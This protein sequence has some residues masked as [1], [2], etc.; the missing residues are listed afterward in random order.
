MKNWYCKPASE[1]EAIEIVRRALANGAVEK[2][3]VSVMAIDGY[4]YKWDVFSFWGVHDGKTITFGATQSA[5][6]RLN[7]Q[8]VRKHFPLPHEVKVMS[9]KEWQGPQDGLPPVGDWVM[10][11]GG[12]KMF[13]VGTSSIGGHVFE[14]EG[15]GL[16]V[17]DSVDG[18][19]QIPN[20]R[21]KWIDYVTGLVK[22]G[23]QTDESLAGEI[24]DALKSG[25]LKA[26]EVEQ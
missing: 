23:A 9:K 25:A 14:L 1:A 6:E 10:S 18:F 8:E 26:P 15:G 2:D 21:D 5:G 4:K 12:A 22:Q 3:V 17:V 11:P 13:Y 24:Y 16:T 19:S 20:E 7:I